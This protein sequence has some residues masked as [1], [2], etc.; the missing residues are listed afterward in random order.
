MDAGGDR[1]SAA[2]TGIV[3]PLHEYD[4]PSHAG[5]LG[6]P[7]GRVQLMGILIGGLFSG[8]GGAVLSVEYTQTWANEIT[9]G[10]GLVAVGLVIVAR[11]PTTGPCQIALHLESEIRN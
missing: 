1:H 9:K 5:K 7:T 3:A 6:V 8:L 11:C 2:G 4:Q 10:R